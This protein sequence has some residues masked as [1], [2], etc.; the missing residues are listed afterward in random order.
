MGALPE[1]WFC[2]RL[3]RSPSYQ[4]AYYVNREKQTLFNQTFSWSGMPSHYK[5]TRVVFSQLLQNK[6]FLLFIASLYM[7]Y[8][9]H[10]SPKAKLFFFFFKAP[11][12]FIF[13]HL[14]VRFLSNI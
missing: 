8:N 3:C 5:G 9:V 14:P 13:K 4:S 7:F 10:F 1:L 11:S 12:V 2:E 6:I